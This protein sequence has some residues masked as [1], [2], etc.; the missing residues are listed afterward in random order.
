MG[1]VRVGG[2]TGVKVNIYPSLS[3]Y[4]KNKKEVIFGGFCEIMFVFGL[5]VTYYFNQD[6]RNKLKGLKASSDRE[7]PCII[8]MTTDMAGQET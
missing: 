3:G 8:A 4:E 2:G 1:G 6:P 7:E 5:I